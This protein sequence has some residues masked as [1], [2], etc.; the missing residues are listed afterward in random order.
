MG[1]PVAVGATVGVTVVVLAGGGAPPPPPP[2]PLDREDVVA[3]EDVVGD[4]E[5]VVFEDVSDVDELVLALDELEDED[6]LELVSVLVSELVDVFELSDEVELDELELD[7]LELEVD[8]SDVEL[9]ELA[10]V[11]GDV[12]SVGSCGSSWE[13]TGGIEGIK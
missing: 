5:L 1:V 11:V 12:E 3:L 9:E 13:A 10:D 8:S 2:P 6:E 4:D 7:E